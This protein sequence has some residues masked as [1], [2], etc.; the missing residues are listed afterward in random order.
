MLGKLLGSVAVSLVLS[1]AYLGGSLLIAR[2]YHYGG[3]L[4]PVMTAWFALY[5]LL[6]VLLYGSVFIAIGSA[7][8]DMKDGQG[9]MT[10]VMLLFA[11]PFFVWQPILEAPEGKLAT[12]MSFVP[13]ATPTL[14][15]LRLSMPP[16][17]PM[18]QVALSL[19]ITILTTAAVVW[20]AGRIFRVG[21]LMQGKSASFTEMLRWLRA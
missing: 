10:P 19:L 4:T 8:T 7:V 6:A 21:V 1:I 17:P 2:Y 11:M 9:L 14:M 15:I 5:L 12:I 3:V 18:W 20:M 16:G 13:I